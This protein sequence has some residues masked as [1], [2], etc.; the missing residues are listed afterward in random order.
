MKTIDDFEKETLI[1][2]TIFI[3][4][5]DS[6][7]EKFDSLV[8]CAMKAGLSA[9][10]ALLYAHLGAATAADCSGACQVN[11]LTGSTQTNGPAPACALTPCFECPTYWNMFFDEMAGRTM[12]RSGITENTAKRCSSFARIEHNPCVGALNTA[13]QAQAQTTATSSAYSHTCLGFRSTML[14]VAIILAPWISFASVLY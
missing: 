9:K 4:S 6:D 1:C 11:A 7:E 5:P 8:Q 10:C 3:L 14:F 2:A 13:E 12:E